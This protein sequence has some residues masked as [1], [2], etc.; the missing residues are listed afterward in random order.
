MPESNSR[1]SSSKHVLLV[2]GQDDKHFVWQLCK[3]VNFPFQ[4][5][6][7]KVD[8]DIGVNGKVFQ[9]LDKG[10]RTDL[11]GSLQLELKA[12]NRMTV[13][14]LMDSDE[15]VMDCWK[16]LGQELAQSGV[17][18]PSSPEAAGT[19]IPG[20]GRIPRTGIWLMPDNQ[21]PGELEDFVWTMIPNG[22]SVLPL[23]K[24]YIGK[25]SESDRRFRKEKNRKAVLYAWLA[26]RKEPG[27][28]GAAVGASDL[29]VNVQSCSKFLCWLER[30]FG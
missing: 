10:N 14:I 30:L 19:V 5:Q 8:F 26:A 29:E 4:P 13:G 7:S 27:R 1:A 24:D 15:N 18:L 28:M 21:S 17:H 23:S 22:D 9:V 6:R 16:V 12:P 2:E 25:I 3:K 20:C 11:I